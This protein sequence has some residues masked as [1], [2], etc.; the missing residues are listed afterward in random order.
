MHPA[1]V[2]CL[3]AARLDVCVLANNHVLDY[4]PAGLVETL[5]TLARAG[6]TSVGAGRAAAE[7]RQPAVV[8]AIGAHRVVVLACAHESSGVP[9]GWAASESRPGVDWLGELSDAAA[10][11]L[12]RRAAAVRRAGDVVVVSI[13]WGSNWGY[14][15]SA[16]Q[17]RFA[18]R[19]IDAGVDVV[20]GHSSHHPRPIEVYRGKLILYGCGD[21]IDDYEGILGYE[22]FRGD[23][24]LLYFPTLDA[25]SGRLVELEMAPMQLHKLRLRRAPAADA[26]WLR[27]MLDEIS[28]PFGARV[29][30]DGHRLRLAR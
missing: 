19:L 20:H 10:L 4:G 6:L 27:R 17:A 24:A 3:T 18:R 29:A 21:L 11:T 2:D 26:E 25:D 28:A 12:G 9:S 15:V 1:N 16:A 23:L 13:H 8:G 30:S 5:E 7:A 14:A 22:E